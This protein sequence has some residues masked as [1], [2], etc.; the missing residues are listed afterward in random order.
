M[1]IVDNDYHVLVYNLTIECMSIR[2][3]YQSVITERKTKKN[4]NTLPNYKQ[5]RPFYSM[6]ER[7]RYRKERE[8]ER[9]RERKRKKKREKGRDTERKG[10]RQ[11]ERERE[12]RREG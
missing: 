3:I 6:R 12:K 11:K 2:A 7:E 9:E 1:F 10:E 4:N 8:R 5:N